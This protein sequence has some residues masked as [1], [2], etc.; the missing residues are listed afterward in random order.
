LCVFL[1]IRRPP[2]STLFPYTTLFRSQG[3]PRERGALREYGEH[4]GLAF[5]IADDLLDA[6]GEAAKVGKATGKDSTAGK[7]TLIGLLG[8]PKARALLGEAEQYATAALKPFEA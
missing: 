3:C 7:A 2:R 5:Q 4:L 1:M 6:E 8:I